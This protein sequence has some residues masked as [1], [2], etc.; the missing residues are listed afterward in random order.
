MLRQ[1]SHASSTIL[2]VWV[3]E[4][5]PVCGFVYKSMGQNVHYWMPEISAMNKLII[6]SLVFIMNPATAPEFYSV[7]IQYYLQ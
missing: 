3:V 5:E 6:K 1:Q 2:H 7:M 4:N